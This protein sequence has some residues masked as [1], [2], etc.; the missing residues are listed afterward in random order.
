MR[1]G[2]KMEDHQGNSEIKEYNSSSDNSSIE[3]SEKPS[4]L[5]SPYSCY[6]ISAN[7]Q[8][9]SITSCGCPVIFWLVI[10]IGL[11]DFYNSGHLTVEYEIS[12]FRPP[13]S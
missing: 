10:R 6:D 13:T 1:N 9:E 12:F 7:Q 2:F 5:M 11:Y 4:D 8:L 3:I